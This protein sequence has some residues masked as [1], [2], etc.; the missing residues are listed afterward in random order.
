ME[1]VRAQRYI[2]RASRL[3]ST[4]TMM[5]PFRS[6]RYLS[7]FNG[8][9]IPDNDGISCISVDAYCPIVI[10]YTTRLQTI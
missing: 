4:R 3:A 8:I 10:W 9:L 5:G 1:T 2:S 7:S 6:G